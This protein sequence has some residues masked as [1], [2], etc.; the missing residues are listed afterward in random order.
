[1]K[2]PRASDRPSTQRWL[3]WLVRIAIAVFAL[4]IAV[5]VAANVWLRAAS[6]GRMHDLEAAPEAPVMIVFGAQLEAGGTRPRPFLRGRLDV[7]VD[8]MRA[9]RA[10]AVLVSG[11]AGGSSGN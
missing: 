7:A 9:G 3:R 2:V 4:M 6:S 10:R 1:M 5:T 11:D 8:L